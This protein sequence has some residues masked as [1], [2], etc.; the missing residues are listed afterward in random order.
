MK[1]VLP[2][3]VV[4]EAAS[5]YEKKGNSQ[6]IL[7]QL[8]ISNKGS[9]EFDL[10]STTYQSFDGTPNLLN[11]IIENNFVV[12]TIDSVNVIHNSYYFT[13]HGKTK[14]CSKFEVQPVGQ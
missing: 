14:D 13:I 1:I 3:P 4:L 7:I 2:E 5:F 8:K 12:Q 9:K 6:K 11:L 10:A